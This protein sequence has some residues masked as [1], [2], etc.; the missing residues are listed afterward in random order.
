[1]CF[2]GGAPRSSAC[3]PSQ[4]RAICYESNT[5]VGTHDSGTSPKG[6]DCKRDAGRGRRR[7]RRWRVPSDRTCI[8][9]LG[10]GATCVAIA[11]RLPARLRGAIR[12]HGYIRSMIRFDLLVGGA[13]PSSRMLHTVKF[14]KADV[15]ERNRPQ[16]GHMLPHR[17][18]TG[19]TGR[20]HDGLGK[21]SLFA[22]EVTPVSSPVDDCCA[23]TGDAGAGD[24]ANPTDPETATLPRSASDSESPPPTCPSDPDS[25]TSTRSGTSGTR[26]VLRV[27]ALGRGGADEAAATTIESS[28]RWNSSSSLSSP[29]CEEATLPTSPARLEIISA[30]GL[31]D[32][33]RL[34]RARFR[35]A[36]Q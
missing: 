27:S 26:L 17:T 34:T 9:I 11:V 4:T 13:I 24:A 8:C 32:G 31:G 15:Y 36:G 6:V 35:P 20:R 16:P 30:D 1:M 2:G 29:P 33:T 19:S 23:R 18:S 7:E 21:N 10:A 5:G 28:T 14:R 3:N 25:D 12:V 22:S